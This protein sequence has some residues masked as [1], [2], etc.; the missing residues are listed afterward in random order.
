M[1]GNE[2]LFLF[3]IFLVIQTSMTSLWFKSGKE[4]AMAIAVTVSVARLVRSY[5]QCTLTQ[6]G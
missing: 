3:D 5:S 2:L 6:S 4:L 1:V